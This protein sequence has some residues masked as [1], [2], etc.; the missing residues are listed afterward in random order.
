MSLLEKISNKF[1]KRQS[2]NSNIKTPRDTVT[3][4][5]SLNIKGKFIPYKKGLKILEDTQVSTGFDILKFILSSK[6]WVLIANDNDNGEVYDFISSMLFNMETEVNEI[7]KKSLTALL[8]GFS[9]QEQIFEIDVN[10][11][12]VV[13][14]V[15]P[16]HIKTLQKDPFVYDEKG[17][18]IAVHQEYKN[19]ESDIP[20]NKILKYS[21]N[22]NY[23]EDYGNGLLSEFKP[24]IEDKININN[25]LMTFLEK[26]ESPTLYGKTGDPRSRDNMLNAFND[27]RDGTTGLVVGL[28]DE[29]GTLESNHRGETF[30]STLQY[31]DNQIFRRYYLGNLLLGDT[32][33]TGTYAQSQTQLDFG[34]LIFDGILE[35]I[36]NNIQKQLINPIVEYNFA[37]TTLAPTFSFDKFTHGDIHKLLAT[38]K[39][40]IDGGVIS[41]ENKTVQ[42]S[43]GMLIK[44]ETGLTYESTQYPV[45]EDFTNP[46]GE[47]DTT[48]TNEIIDEISNLI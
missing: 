26:H 48:Q 42:D 33:Q 39:P 18:L 24:I 11:R 38:I 28:E 25:W 32:S 46:T 12:L 40:L 14:N 13:K 31:K 36:A 5:Y 23:D 9:V 1:F 8:W 37:D 15:L 29:L 19:E 30:F 3:N 20:I 2:M 27:V 45:F 35:E 17:E 6:E 47:I 4:R 44:Q 34:Q 22:A 43:I 41:S 21:F 16:L 10:G 7:V